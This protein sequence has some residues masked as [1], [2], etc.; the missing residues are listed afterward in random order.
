[1][2]SVVKVDPDDVF[3]DLRTEGTSLSAI[4]RDRAKMKIELM[5]TIPISTIGESLKRH[6]IA[7]R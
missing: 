2:E 3:N 4:L 7:Y 5:K 6:F 1:M